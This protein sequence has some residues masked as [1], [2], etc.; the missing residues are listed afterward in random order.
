MEMLAAMGPNK[1]GDIDFHMDGAGKSMAQIG[2]VNGSTNGST[3]HVTAQ[4]AADIGL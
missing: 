2:R 1:A 4:D 3:G